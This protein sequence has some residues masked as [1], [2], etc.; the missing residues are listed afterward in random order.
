MNNDLN[1]VIIALNYISGFSK[2][3]ARTLLDLAHN[4]LKEFNKISF[5][6]IVEFGV[7]RGIFLRNQPIGLFL[8]AY[9]HAK[10]VIEI[11]SEKEIHIINVF[12]S[13]FP[14]ALKFENSPYIFYYYGNLDSLNNENRA[15]VVGSRH[16]NL[17]GKEFAY[18]ISELLVNDGYTVISGLAQGCD[19][20][21]HRAAIANKGQ[22]VAFIP[23]NLLRINPIQNIEL[24]NEIV[25]NNGLIITEYSPLST[26]NSS[27]YITRDRLQ[28]G[29]TNVVFVSQFD[30][31]SGTLQTLEFASKFNKP[32]YTLKSLLEDKDFN[33]YYSLYEK[34]I[35]CKAL[36]WNE[37]ETLIK[38]LKK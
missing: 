13:N 10:K 24:A 31:Q 37:L 30:D 14:N 8:D 22:T 5:P 15:T 20:A 2:R 11:C 3:K 38:S 26:P 34:A 23:S 29:S 7:E 19:S 35:E 28:A 21:A 9:E 33:G 4:S 32:I 1:T 17:E 16:P 36:T 12:D 25:D 18:N 27:M 6:A